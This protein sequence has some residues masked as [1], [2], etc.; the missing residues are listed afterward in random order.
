GRDP[1]QGR[2]AR[3]AVLDGVTDQVRKNLLE[4]GRVGHHPRHGPCLDGRARD[5]DRSPEPAQGTVERG[6]RI[7]YLEGPPRRRHSGEGEQVL[8]LRLHPDSAVDD[9]LDV[10]VS[11]LAELPLITP[12]EEL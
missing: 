7:R 11:I 5:A 3:A 1:D 12:L 6:A 4:L 9:E 10:L 8:Y 2:H